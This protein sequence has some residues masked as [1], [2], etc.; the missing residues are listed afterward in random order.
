MSSLKSEIRNPRFDTNRCCPRSYSQWWGVARRQIMLRC[1]NVRTG[2]ES[3]YLV[4]G[5][6]RHQ[7][8]HAGGGGCSKLNMHVYSKPRTRAFLHDK[9]NL[10]TILRSSTSRVKGRSFEGRFLF[11]LARCDWPAAERRVC[12]LSWIGREG[13]EKWLKQEAAGRVRYGA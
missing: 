11:A 1:T 9:P 7:H 3:G 6:L 10:S 12:C 2:K 8:R 4:V 13:V 5:L